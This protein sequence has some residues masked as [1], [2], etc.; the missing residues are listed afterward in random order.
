MSIPE[1]NVEDDNIEIPKPV[2]MP[3]IPGLTQDVS[4]PLKAVHE[5]KTLLSINDLVKTVRKRNSRFSKKSRKQFRKEPV[6]T[7]EVGSKIRYRPPLERG[8]CALK[9]INLTTP[10]KMFLD[11]RVKFIFNGTFLQALDFR[12]FLLLKIPSESFNRIEI[13]NNKGYFNDELLVLRIRQ[14]PFP[15]TVKSLDFIPE[16]EDLS[17]Q[18]D[19]D[20]DFPEQVK[21]TYTLEKKY[22]GSITTVYARDFVDEFGTSL[23]RNDEKVGNTILTYLSTP[24]DEIKLKATVKRN[25]G[26]EHINWTVLDVFY[27]KIDEKITFNVGYLWQSERNVQIRELIERACNFYSDQ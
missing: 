1:Q 12:R 19:D 11:E 18:T 2:D 14:L 6:I 7:S 21:K 17:E 27:G 22:Q 20:S 3:I 15:I 8:K 5:T 26:S 13:T 10:S 9:G 24:T 23:Y 25:L 16:D 4:R